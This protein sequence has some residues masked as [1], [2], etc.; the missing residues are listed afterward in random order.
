MADDIGDLLKEF[1][2]THCQIVGYSFGGLIA[3]MVNALNTRSVS[4]LV[5]LEPALLEQMSIDELRIVRCQYAIAAS[6]LLSDGDPVVGV[7]QFL[8]LISPNRST[9]PRVERMTVQ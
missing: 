7:T 1:S 3:L 8:N 4:D 9:H 5:L 2:V 6:A